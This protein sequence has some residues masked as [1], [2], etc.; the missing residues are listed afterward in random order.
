MVVNFNPSLVW[1]KMEV[2]L[3]PKTET[4]K[5]AWYFVAAS[6]VGILLS[7]WVIKDGTSIALQ[8]TTGY[9]LPAKKNKK[10]VPRLF[11]F[12]QKPH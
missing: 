6:V 10:A 2:Q 7:Y 1:K 11:L 9:K 12:N 8:K 4:T 3:H 5:L